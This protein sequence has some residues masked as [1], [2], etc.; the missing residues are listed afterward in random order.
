MEEE[1]IDPCAD[2]GHLEKI[3]ILAKIRGVRSILYRGVKQATNTHRSI[4]KS[5]ESERSPK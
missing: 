4:K 5:L 1:G 3:R 2:I